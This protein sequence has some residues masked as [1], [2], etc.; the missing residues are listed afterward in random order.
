VD[1]PEGKSEGTPD[2]AAMFEAAYRA[3]YPGVLQFARMTDDIDPE[4]AVQAAFSTLW[5]R[6]TADPP[7][8]L[9]DDPV[10]AR[11]YILTMVQR[12]IASRCRRA[13]CLERQSVAIEDS[14]ATITRDWMD[15][16][17][18]QD[19]RDRRFVIVQALAILSP[20]CREAFTLVRVDG[21]SYVEAAV[22]QGVSPST[23]HQQVSH[24][25]ML[26]R[27]FLT[28]HDIPALRSA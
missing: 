10:Q 11:N 13:S 20:R 21:C 24:A 5:V 9:P 14:V 1:T 22:I 16:E 18:E 25:N 6:Y 28:S 15:P 23:I 8:L 12:T 7:L 3:H 19:H 17:A 4:D 27:A 26:I 2:V